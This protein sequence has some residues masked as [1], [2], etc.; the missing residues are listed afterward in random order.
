MPVESRRYSIEE[1]LFLRESP[2][3]TNPELPAQMEQWI[4]QPA[5][6]KRAL[7]NSQTQYVSPFYILYKDLIDAC[8]VAM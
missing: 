4:M 6:E 2:L 1:L 3:V 8:E 5:I 7:Q